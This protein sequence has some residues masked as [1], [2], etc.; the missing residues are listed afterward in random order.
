M[1]LD[2]LQKLLSM[3]EFHKIVQVRALAVT[4]DGS[5]TLML[6]FDPAYTLVRASGAYHGGV[7]ATLIDVAGTMSCSVVQGRPTPTANLRVDY[8]KS[9]ASCDLYADSIVRRVGRLLGTAD[10]TIRDHGGQVYAIG[11]GTFVMA[12]P[13]TSPRAG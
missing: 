10:V 2:Q 3:A 1:T 9:P 5:L 13:E 4:P 11:R 6:P 7:I 8:L 12:A